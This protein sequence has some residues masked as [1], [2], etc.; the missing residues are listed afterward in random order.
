M[1]LTPLENAITRLREGL[2]IYAS[3]P[4]QTIVRDGVVQRFEFTYEAAHRMLKRALEAASADPEQFDL[5]S[6]ADLVRS[7]NEADLLAGDWPRWRTYRDMRARTSHTYNEAV[8]L[9]VVAGIGG[10]LAEAEYLRD[11][12]RERGL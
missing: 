5:M 3:D 10:F 8:A 1:D 6:F 12:L 2:A 7:G 11:R 4:S 9:D